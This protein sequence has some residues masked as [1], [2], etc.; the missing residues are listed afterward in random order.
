MHALRV[1]VPLY[2]AALL[3]CSPHIALFLYRVF[4]FSSLS[5]K[6]IYAALSSQNALLSLHDF[7]IIIFVMHIFA[8][9]THTGECSDSLYA[10]AKEYITHF[11]S[12]A[13]V[14][15]GGGGGCKI[16]FTRVASACV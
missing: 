5:F 4:F 1:C 3:R 16:F 14:S 7:R 10:K 9:N 15:R 11:S 13:R 2:V 12:H 8:H 6:S